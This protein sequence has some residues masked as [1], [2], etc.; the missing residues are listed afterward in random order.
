MDDGN[1]SGLFHDPNIERID[2]IF[3]TE[4]RANPGSPKEA[5]YAYQEMAGGSGPLNL[6]EI[7]LNE[8]EK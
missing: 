3:G 6:L 2:Y 4:T 8:E 7:I 5:A 1:N